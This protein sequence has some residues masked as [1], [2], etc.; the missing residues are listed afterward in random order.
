MGCCLG[1]NWVVNPITADHHQEEEDNFM[2]HINTISSTNLR[3]KVRMTKTQFLELA[4]SSK[5]NSELGRMI[6]QECLEG[7]LR[8]RILVDQGLKFQCANSLSTIKEE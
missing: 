4:D 3:M 5:N 1:R 2:S 8:S 6:L 7:R